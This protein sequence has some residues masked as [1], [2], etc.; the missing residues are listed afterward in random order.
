MQVA[1]E[2]SKSLRFWKVLS[3]VPWSVVGLAA[4]ILVFWDALAP[5]SPFGAWV[6][7]QYENQVDVAQ[8]PDWLTIRQVPWT[9]GVSLLGASL[10]LFLFRWARWEKKDQAERKGEFKRDWFRGRIARFPLVRVLLAAGVYGCDYA[11]RRNPDWFVEA[12]RA[13]AEE[14]VGALVMAFALLAAA[15][16]IGWIAGRLAIPGDRQI[17][18]WLEELIES[19]QEQS[20]GKLGLVR[21]ELTKGEI[22]LI[23]FTEDLRLIPEEDRWVRKGK[24][25][26]VR[27]TPLSLTILQFTERHVGVY[28]CVI[29]FIR[30][31]QLDERTD[32]FF[33]QDVVSVATQRE[34]HAFTLY[35]V[36]VEESLQFSLS[37]SSGDRVTQR[38]PIGELDKFVSP[39]STQA[40]QAVNNIRQM[41]REKK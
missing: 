18:Q 36:K 8:A 34:S 28:R 10:L 3:L 17:D 22:T 24:D 26:V 9:L 32:E 7:I 2:V 5:E 4:F 6:R 30:D 20:L 27:F 39:I 23:G 21:E 16:L 31:V 33:Y 35:G 40:E 13:V 19:T 29:N 38:L 15:G 41:L 1:R 14:G 37:V 25:K 12:R 11:I